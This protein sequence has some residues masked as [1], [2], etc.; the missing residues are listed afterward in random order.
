[1]SQDTRKELNMPEWPE[2]AESPKTQQPRRRRAHRLP[3]EP[4]DLWGRIRFRVGKKTR[5]FGRRCRRVLREAR[6]H[7]FPESNRW[8][9]QF[10]LM[11]WG[12]LP[13]LASRLRGDPAGPPQG[14]HPPHQPVCP[15]V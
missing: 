5:W 6:A 13:A 8:L 12:L 7:R 9:L 10:L 14:P 4:T 15:V 2:E 3:P 11:V 1:M